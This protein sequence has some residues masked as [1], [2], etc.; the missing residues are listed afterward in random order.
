M[1][2]MPWSMGHHNDNY[3]ICRLLKY[4]VMARFVLTDYVQYF[5]EIITQVVVVLYSYNNSVQVGVVFERELM[6][7]SA[8]I[9]RALLWSP[10][11]YCTAD[12]PCAYLCGRPCCGAIH[13]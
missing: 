3:W 11:S 5:S 9:M 2:C 8:D 6:I 13:L 10:T 1:V 7:G 4:S 12:V